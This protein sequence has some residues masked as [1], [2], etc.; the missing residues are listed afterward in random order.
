MLRKIFLVLP[1]LFFEMEKMKM[2]Q[3]VL[4][5][6]LRP[7][8]GVRAASNLVVSVVPLC[9][10]FLMDL[11]VVVVRLSVWEGIFV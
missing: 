11:V 4:L 5:D 1:E 2:R 7:A 10:R 6:H 8:A 9:V 3:Q